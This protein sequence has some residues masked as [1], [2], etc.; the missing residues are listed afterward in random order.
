MI[1]KGEE[2]N[3]VAMMVVSDQ[4]KTRPQISSLPIH[5]FFLIVLLLSS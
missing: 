1:Q 4:V 5:C 3:I 2:T